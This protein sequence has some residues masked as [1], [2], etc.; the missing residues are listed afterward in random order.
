[1]RCGQLPDGTPQQFY[2]PDD[3][4]SIPGWFKGMKVII[5]ERRIWPD[6][7]QSGRYLKIWPDV[8]Q[9]VL[10]LNARPI[11]PTAAVVA[12]SSISRIFLPRNHTCKNSS[13]SVATCVTTTQSITVNLIL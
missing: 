4:S 11:K 10:T 13:K 9:S 8:S 1:M 3:H 6:V 12:S 7:S 2:F 5:Q